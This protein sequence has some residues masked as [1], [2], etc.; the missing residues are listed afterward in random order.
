MLWFDEIAAL[1][2]EKED[3]WVLL[4]DAD[5]VALRNPD[6]L[7]DRAGVDVL[8]TDRRRPDP[9]FVAVRGRVLKEFGAAWRGRRAGRPDDWQDGHGWALMAALG[10]GAWRVGDFERGE[11]VR[12]G[13]TGVG[14]GEL[15]NAAVIHFGGMGPEDKRRLAFAFHAMAVYGDEDGLFLDMME[16]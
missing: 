9:G 6:H 3:Q 7:F 15:K 8:V 16:S 5:C 1:D 13:D 4:M 10:S 12:A 11:V 14:L 2:G